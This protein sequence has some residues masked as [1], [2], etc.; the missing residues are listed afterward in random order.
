MLQSLLADSSE[1]T[2]V[3]AGLLLRVS[4]FDG[5]I[6]GKLILS[7]MTSLGDADCGTACFDVGALTGTFDPFPFDGAALRKPVGVESGRSLGAPLV[8][9]I[10]LGDADCRAAC[11]D[12]GA[13]TGTF[14]PF[15][16]DGAALRKPEGDESGRSLGG[17]FAP[18][19]STILL[20]RSLGSEL[21]TML[22]LSLG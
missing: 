10:S 16:F 21:G 11:F 18:P 22:G 14:D 4:W 3:N 7:P 20:G 2:F 6:E 9:E 12:V 17:A 8:P 1:S 15:P 19:L 13:L 5:M